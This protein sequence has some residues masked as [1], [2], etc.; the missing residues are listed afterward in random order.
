MSRNR[1]WRLLLFSAS[2]LLV[3]P[4]PGRAQPNQPVCTTAGEQNFPQTTSDGAGG[5]IITW[6]DPGASAGIHAHHVLP[7]GVVDPAWPANG[8][9][10]CTAPDHQVLPAIVSDGAGGAIV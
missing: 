5:A 4:G 1:V 7:S 10:L 6:E 9:A 8:T 3:P 2:F